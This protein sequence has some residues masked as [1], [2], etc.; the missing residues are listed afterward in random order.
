MDPTELMMKARQSDDELEEALQGA[1][2]LAGA[3]GEARGAVGGAC[4]GFVVISE[5]FI[6]DSLIEKLREVAQE[7]SGDQEVQVLFARAHG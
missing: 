6:E 4:P 7:N 2:I 3:A 5:T 1:V